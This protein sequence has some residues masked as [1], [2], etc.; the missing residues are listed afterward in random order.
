MAGVLDVWADCVDQSPPAN[1]SGALVRICDSQAHVAT[2]RLVDDL[3]EQA[4]LESLLETVEPPHERSFAGLH[5]LLAAP[6][7]YPPL[8]HGSR[9]GTRLEPSLFYGA[10]AVETVLAEAAYYRFVFF[11]GMTEPPPSG[12]IR[13]QHTIFGVGYRTRQGL[14]LQTPPWSRHAAAIASPTDYGASQR[15]GAALRAGGVQAF[16]YPSARDPGGGINVALFTPAA[17]AAA[18]PRFQQA[19]LC[20]TLATAVRYAGTHPVACHAFA[21]TDFL[22]GGALPEPAI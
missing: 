20:E 11:C 2:S 16:E 7:R 4:V 22:V 8:R 1:L 9:F 6:F 15:L 10:L 13:S 17:L 14:R 21:L 5:P 3:G 18:R 19:W 12:R